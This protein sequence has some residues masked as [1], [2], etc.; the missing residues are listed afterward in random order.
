MIQLVTAV[1]LVQYIEAQLKSPEHLDEY[2]KD[3]WGEHFSTSSVAAVVGE[4]IHGPGTLANET[5][6]LV[7]KVNEAYRDLN[8]NECALFFHTLKWVT[9]VQI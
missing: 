5:T 6:G 4:T 2:N 7:A 3:N 8:Q 9:N 1:A